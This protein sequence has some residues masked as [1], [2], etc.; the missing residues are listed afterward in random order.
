M[1]NELTASEYL[2]LSRILAEICE[3][4]SH[5]IDINSQIMK[6][7]IQIKEMMFEYEL[8]TPTGHYYGVT[9]KTCLDDPRE[10]Y[11]ACPTCGDGSGYC[12]SVHHWICDICGS[13]IT[14]SD[15]KFGQEIWVC[16]ECKVC[17]ICG[18]PSNPEDCPTCV[19]LK[20]SKYHQELYKGEL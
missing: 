12:S 18:D 8:T 11:P 14:E 1:K 20:Q 15:N 4:A 5:E 19:A 9:W 2:S 6:I 13:D 16:I 17:E 7:A 3:E 10:G